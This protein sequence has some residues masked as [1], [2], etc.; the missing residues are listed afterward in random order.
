M[1]NKR[2]LATAV[3]LSIMTT[4]ITASFADFG[5]FGKVKNLNFENRIDKSE[6]TEEQIAEKK[7]ERETQKMEMEAREAV[8]D[9]LLNGETLTTEQESIRAD[10]IEDRAAR[11]AE[12]AEMEAKREEIKAILEKKKNGED[13][14]EDE[15]ALLEE[16]KPNRG[17]NR[18]GGKWRMEIPTESEFN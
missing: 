2:V 9:A 3:A 8:I 11:K 10:I 17:W 5:W 12:K 4:G 13:L 6:L 14:T 18:K 7:A 15:T 1:K 16:M